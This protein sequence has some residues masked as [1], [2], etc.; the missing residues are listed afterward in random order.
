[1]M[2]RHTGAMSP[3][4]DQAQ[5]R[6]PF[7]EK[8]FYQAEFRGRTLALALPD[9]GSAGVL[10]P[11][12][13]ELAQ[14]RTRA[15][16][17]S[18]AP[19]VFEA[20]PGTKVLGAGQENLE[21]AV[22]RAFADAPR[23]GVVVEGAKPFAAGVREVAL[24]LAVPKLVWLDAGGGLSRPDGSRRSF[25]DLEELREL[26]AGGFTDASAERAALLSEI[27]QALRAGVPA[28]NLCSAEGLADELFTYAGVG[29]LFTRERYVDVRRLGIDDY[30]A[31]D[32]LIARGVAE[33]Y[34]APRAPAEVDRVLAN[35]FGA[36]VEGRHLA[37]IGAL[38]DHAEAGAGEIAS[39]YTLTRFLGEGIGGHLIAF[40]LEAAR[41]RGHD[42]VFACTGSPPAAR[43]FERLGFRRVDADSLPSSK[44][45]GYDPARRARVLCLR[46]DL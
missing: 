33:G 19:G 5:A 11:V 6:A 20:L 36:F 14:N 46:R 24:R 42:H 17:I 38:L 37:G 12:L 16:L 13:A 2:I 40:A 27:E 35:G 15:V 26:A 31:A 41:R 8:A 9:P 44:W 43:F 3:R 23:V 22:W 21:G 30:D 28:V 32:D 7:S 34:L 45:R 29:T 10:E 39:L 4:P 25:V 18:P 1:M